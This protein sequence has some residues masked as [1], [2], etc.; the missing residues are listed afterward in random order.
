MCVAAVAGKAHVALIAVLC[1]V[2]RWPDEKL[3]SRFITRFKVL[4]RMENS[5]LFPPTCEGELVSKAE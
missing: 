5:G 4:G 1:Y 3:P 2:M